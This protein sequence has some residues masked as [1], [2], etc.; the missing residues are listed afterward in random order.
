VIVGNPSSLSGGNVTPPWLPVGR[1]PGGPGGPPRRELLL[2]PGIGGYD[3]LEAADGPGGCDEL[4][5]VGAVVGSRDAAALRTGFVPDEPPGPGFR[6]DVL[7]EAGPEGGAGGGSLLGTLLRRKLD[8][9]ADCTLCARVFL[10]GPRLRG[11]SSHV[12][13]SS[14][15]KQKVSHHI[16]SSSMEMNAKRMEEVGK[17]L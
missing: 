7:P 17:R 1:D 5:N 14:R 12:Q 16:R 4:P 15:S 2:D 9:P 8:S 3:E 11:A 13:D 6:L 10:P